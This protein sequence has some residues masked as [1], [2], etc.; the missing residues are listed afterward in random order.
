MK[1]L[2]IGLG[3]IANKHI[4][5]LRSMCDDVEIYALRSGVSVNKVEGVTDIY[6]LSDLP[7]SID[8]AI[9]SNSTNLHFHFIEKMADFGIPMFIEKPVVHDTA[10]LAKLTDLLS[11]QRVF[12]YVACNLRF[13]PSIQFLKSALKEK[14]EKINEVNVYCGS[15]L[16][17]WR[18]GTNF[19]RNYSANAEMGGGVHLDLFHELDYSWWLFGEPQRTRKFASNNS[20]LG[21][22]AMDYANFLLS[23]PDFNISI[24]LNYYRSKPKRTIEILFETDTWTIDMLSNTIWNDKQDIIFQKE[25]YQLTLTYIDQ[26]RYFVDC[27]K[28]K[29]EPMN[30]ISESLRILKT[31]LS[32]G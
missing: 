19:R 29:Q 23:Y 15:F 24:V 11:Q 28:S 27:L 3:S 25:D 7:A 20:S 21:I 12:S 22:T 8:F 4:N 26:M 30:T 13:H 32:N 10:S 31:C 14:K 5:A 6:N 16:P 2:I 18:P 1:V 17:D 9:I